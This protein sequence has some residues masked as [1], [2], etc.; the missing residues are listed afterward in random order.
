LQDYFAQIKQACFKTIRL[1]ISPDVLDNRKQVVDL[2]QEAGYGPTEMKTLTQTVDA[3]ERAGLWVVLDCNGHG[4]KVSGGNA[5]APYD[6]DGRY[7]VKDWLNDLARMALFAQQ[8]HY[9]AR[10]DLFNEPQGI[11]W[12]ER[13]GLAERG[14]QQVLRY[15]PSL[16]VFVQGV[17][18]TRTDSAG[19]GAFWAGK[20]HRS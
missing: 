13:K 4:S 3:A 16:L 8:R 6:Q 12:S 2:A 17:T 14:G 15:K 9:G 20:L 18:E 19:Y 5:P 1:T 7:K 11:S 10:I